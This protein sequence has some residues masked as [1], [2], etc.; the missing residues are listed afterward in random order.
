MSDAID[1]PGG[2]RVD[3]PRGEWAD[4]ARL[5][6]EL[7]DG[8]FYLAEDDDSPLVCARC[9]CSNCNIFFKGSSWL[10]RECLAKDEAHVIRLSVAIPAPTREELAEELHKAFS[11]A[12]DRRTVLAILLRGRTFWQGVT[13]ERAYL[14]EEVAAE[15]D[16]DADALHDEADGLR[17]NARLL[18]AWAAES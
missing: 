15:A 11:E 7:V 4:G 5:T 16:A 9:L 13:A 6:M 8:R 10:C 3:L 12:L 18:R 14:L 2:V 1:L 17:A